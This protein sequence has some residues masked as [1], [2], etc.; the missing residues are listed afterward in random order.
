MS[1][2]ERG[3]KAT[4][5]LQETGIDCII[6][7]AVTDTVTVLCGGGVMAYHDGKILML[8]DHVPLS[9]NPVPIFVH[10]VVNHRCMTVLV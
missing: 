10:D 8:G 1:E 5:K 2:R 7:S 9:E 6:D 4:V 3:A